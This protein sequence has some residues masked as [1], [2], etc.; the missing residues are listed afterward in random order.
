M[1]G[2]FIGKTVSGFWTFKECKWYELTDLIFAEIDDG[3]FSGCL[4]H[5]HFIDIK[6]YLVFLKC[7]C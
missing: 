3:N 1:V 4:H 6:L 2:L 7:L 5:H